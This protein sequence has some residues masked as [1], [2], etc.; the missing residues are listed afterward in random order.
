M[1]LFIKQNLF[2]LVLSTSTFAIFCSLLFLSFS[3]SDNTTDLLSKSESLFSEYNELITARDSL[4]HSEN[5][6]NTALADLERI[7]AKEKNLSNFLLYLLNENENLSSKWDS[8]SAESVNASLTRLF[9][10][11]RKKC[12]ESNISLPSED[13]QSS[14]TSPFSIKPGNS[15]NDSFGFSFSSYDGNWPSFSVE[16]A[17]KIGVQ[18]EIVKE[19]VNT[20]SFC[21]DENH[22]IQIQ[23]ILREEV[24]EV[25][26]LNISTDRIDLP[27]ISSSFMRDVPGI[28]SFVFKVSLQ[29]QTLSLRKFVNGLRPPFQIREISIQPIENIELSSATNSSF[30][31]DPFNTQDTVNDRYIPIVSKVD[32]KVDLILE[33]IT[34]AER[35]L[36]EISEKVVSHPYLNTEI[37]FKWLTSSGNQDSIS[38]TESFFN[39]SINR[40]TVR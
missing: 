22:T 30:T 3:Y 29:I 32:S 21:T 19:I 17:R 26:K 36:A 5:D 1:K 27:E 13:L 4:S 9:S 2:F 7:S 12:S 34:G 10:R 28:D 18:S 20:L 37:Y 35:N 39:E 11:L 8:K 14:S 15:V 25:D 40:K 33:Y 23:S 38:D 31:P 24:G 16:E 6:Y